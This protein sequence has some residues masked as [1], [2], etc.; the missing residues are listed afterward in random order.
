MILLDII[1]VEVS[2]SL[3]LQSDDVL[4]QRQESVDVHL[5]TRSELHVRHWTLHGL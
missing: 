1:C 3:V 5:L 2:S 4:Q